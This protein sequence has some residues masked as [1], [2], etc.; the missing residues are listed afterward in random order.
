MNRFDQLINDQDRLLGAKKAAL[1]GA[2]GKFEALQK[3]REQA[4]KEAMI[5]FQA[6]WTRALDETYG[7]LEK[8]ISVFGKTG[9]EGWD[10]MVNEAKGRV[11]A[12]DVA[13]LSNDDLA[14][15]F[16]KAEVLPMVMSIVS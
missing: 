1:D 6:D 11:Q 3:S 13:A 8:E 16:Y 7:K 4:A 2:Q 12:V 5:T 15:R 14:A 9:D 10:K